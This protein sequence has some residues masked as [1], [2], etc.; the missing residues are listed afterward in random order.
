MDIL[1]EY[2]YL[3][4]QGAITTVEL[5]ALSVFFSL[6]G[7]SVVGALRCYGGRVV[8]AL[9]GVPVD[10]LRSIPLLVVLIWIFFAAPAA[11]GATYISPFLAAVVGLSLTEGAYISEIVRG[12]L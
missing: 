12:G 3:F 8:S 6:I 1:H 11:V 9:L 4:Q 5:T 7:G 10:I 2:G